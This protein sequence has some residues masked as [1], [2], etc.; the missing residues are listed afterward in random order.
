[1]VT[2]LIFG[3]KAGYVYMYLSLKKITLK[4]FLKPL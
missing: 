3:D 1:M 4:S 2:L